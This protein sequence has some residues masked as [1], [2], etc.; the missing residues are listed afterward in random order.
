MLSRLY[1]IVK[2]VCLEVEPIRVSF[3]VT[4]VVHLITMS[5]WDSV[6]TFMVLNDIIFIASF[7]WKLFNYL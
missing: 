6:R 4:S 1:L 3:G 5:F 7:L 2:S